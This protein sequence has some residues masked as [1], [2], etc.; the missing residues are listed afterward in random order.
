[1]K[2]IYVG[3]KRIVGMTQYLF[4]A[5]YSTHV[6]HFQPPRIWMYI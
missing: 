2:H 6:N 3:E 5:L 1:M 4:A